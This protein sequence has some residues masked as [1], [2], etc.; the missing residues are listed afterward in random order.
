MR[1]LVILFV[2]N[3]FLLLLDSGCRPPHCW[4]LESTLSQTLHNLQVSSG[5]VSY[6]SQSFIP[7][8]TQQTQETDIHASGGIRTRNPSKQAGVGPHL[9]LRGYRD[10]RK[11]SFGWLNKEGQNG[12][13]LW[14]L[15]ERREIRSPFWWRNPR[16]C[17]S[18]GFLTVDGRVIF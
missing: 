6:P 15:W 2:K 9:L 5:R 18:L 16:K 10:R 11:I 4:G 7:N 3:L 12:R 8:N 14:L 17:G 13:S 1:N